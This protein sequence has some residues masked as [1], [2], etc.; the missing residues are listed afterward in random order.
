MEP[1]MILLTTTLLVHLIGR[2]AVPTWRP[3]HIALRVG[4]AAMFVATG[5]AHFIGMRD[6][7]IAMVPPA[8]PAPGLL[9]TVTGVLELGAAAG[10]FWRPLRPWAAGGL[11]LL[12]I[13]MFPANIYKAIGQTDLAWSDTLVPRTVLQVVFLAAVTSVLV[14]DI[15][16][17]PRAVAGA[18]APVEQK[19]G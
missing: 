3:W 14:W 12:L 19:S 16:K 1:L 9:V 13:G 7:L 18:A 8:L 11:V 10:L 4:V 2:V 6:E 15:H 17:R 5:G